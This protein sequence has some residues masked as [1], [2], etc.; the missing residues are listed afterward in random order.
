MDSTLPPDDTAPDL[1]LEPPSEMPAPE[2]PAA[3]E[4]VLETTAEA[5]PQPPLDGEASPKEEL[6]ELAAR[7]DKGRLSAP[8]EDRAARAIKACLLDGRAG[9]AT[10][11]ELI[12]R[13]AWMVAVHG[14]S[15]AWPELTAGF[16]TQLFSGLSKDESDAARR[17]RLSLA[18]G[19]FKLDVPSALK[20]AVGVAREVRDKE[21]GALASKDAQMF[22]NVFIGRAKPWLAGLPLAE[23]K[24]ADADALVH[25]ALVAAFSLPHPPVTQLGVLK[26][27]ADA[28]RLAKLH[29]TAL[30]AIIKTVSRWNPKWQGALRKEV[31]GLPEEIAAILPGPTASPEPAAPGESSAAEASANDETAPAVETADESRE[32]D[33]EDDDDEEDGAPAPARQY[34]VYVP[35]TV[36][37]REP[38]PRESAKREQP[39]REQA[40]RPS[41]RGGQSAANFNV[42]DALRQ[43]DA[44]VAY[45][46]GELK[47]AQSKARDE[48]RRPRRAERSTQIIHGEPTVEE[49]ARQNHQLEARIEELQQR[50]TDLTTDSEDR[51]A[52]S[53]AGTDQPVA[54]QGAALRALLVL[55]L[56]EDYADF[57]ALER[58]SIDV[59]VQAHY[60]TLLQ[61]IFEVLTQEGVELKKPT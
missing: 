33:E 44:H 37:T 11:V 56:Q 7:A 38:A 61:H 10:V 20:L 12:P 34:P 52:S 8:D 50:I 23:L 49:L 5:A 57:V 4:P 53:G 35:R 6:A 42:A 2:I 14:V 26:W 46:R 58:E 29:E 39:P 3:P 24:P 16:R 18:R 41:Q 25:C 55:K 15:A 19:I 40:P 60:R 36:S 9:V 22:A 59:V 32:R 43:I 30:E 48:E 28:G 47:T 45:L 51:A 21:T 17:L 1:P 54:D 27:A 13:F 31:V